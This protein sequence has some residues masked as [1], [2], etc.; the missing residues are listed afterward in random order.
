[1]HLPSTHA[2]CFAA[3]R[4]VPRAGYPP[5]EPRSSGLGDPVAP[6]RGRPT[7]PAGAQ[8]IRSSLDSGRLRTWSLAP[9]DST[10]AASLARELGIH[11]V[12]AQCL[13]NRGIDDVADAREFLDGSLGSLLPPDDLP[14]IDAAVARI[15]RALAEGEQICVWG[16]YDVDGLTGAAIVTRFLRMQGARVLP[17]VPDRSGTGYGFDWPT[18]Q[19]MIERGVTLFVSVDHGSTAVDEVALAK[20]HGADVVIA[21][22]HEMSPTLPD[23][24]AVINPKRPDSEYA[25]PSLCGAGVGMKLCWAVA[26]DLSPGSRVS[27]EMRG[28]LLDAL[29]LAVL[30]TVADVVPLVGEN[31]IIVRHGLRVLAARRM[32]G[33]AALLDVSRATPPF[34]AEDVGFRLGPRINA[35][36]R[37]G[38][39]DLAL[40]LL[41]TDDPVRAAEIA[42]RLDTENDRRR[43]VERD[44]ADQAR[45]R[46]L[47]ELGESPDGGIAVLGSSWHH[48]VV[49]IVASRL[50]DQFHLPSIVVGVSDGLGRGS[51]RSVPGFALHEALAACSE[52]LVSHGGHAA[53]AGLT[54]E[55]ERFPAFQQAFDAYVREHLPRDAR[56]PKLHLDAAVDLDQIGLELVGA[57]DRLAPFGAANRAP[58]LLLRD[59]QVVGRPR[60]MGRQ[61]EHVSF[62]VGNDGNAI[63]CV[64]FRKAAE[65]WP[66]LQ[67]GR[68]LDVALRVK[69]NEFRGR[70]DVEA[71]VVDLRSAAE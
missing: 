3:R 54:I 43:K 70:S 65:F 37:M 22:H 32:A 71:H 2:G 19:G 56:R 57:L 13:L 69:R 4:S 16:D 8:V 66:M 42:Q 62:F 35:A 36:G 39:A 50:V 64:A 63:R 58:V 10:R 28:F 48:G 59:V 5:S 21:D 1:M 24:V 7:V 27:D 60:R 11:P 38:S 53:A 40:E 44:V 12:A 51:A 14:D 34:T 55:P 67:T 52:H 15:R 6:A 29:G 25:F 9:A 20:E 33:T 23:A 26:Q 45:A 30:G 41:L 68:R 17:F 31:R 18:M 47:D 49:G 46:V 61:D